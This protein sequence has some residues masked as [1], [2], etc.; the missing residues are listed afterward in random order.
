MRDWSPPENHTAV[1]SVN[2][3]RNASSLASFSSFA[4]SNVTL[5]GPSLSQPSRN[6][7]ALAGSSASTLAVGTTTI[8][9]FSFPASSTNAL[10]TDSG[11]PPPPTITSGPGKAVIGGVGDFGGGGD[12]AK[13]GAVSNAARRRIRRI[14]RF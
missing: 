6:E 10:R 12:W 5:A 8:L 14:F 4:C 2:G 7:S 1:A 13:S 9:A 3:L 11:M